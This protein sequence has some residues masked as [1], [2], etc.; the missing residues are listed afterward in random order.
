MFKASFIGLVQVL[1][2]SGVSACQLLMIPLLY[3]LREKRT[4][5]SLIQS[6]GSL[7]DNVVRHV[8]LMMAL[9]FGVGALPLLLLL[10]LGLSLGQDISVQLML[11]FAKKILRR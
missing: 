2:A 9:N 10:D 7:I 3:W 5:L 1:R 8:I 11:G 6:S 4:L